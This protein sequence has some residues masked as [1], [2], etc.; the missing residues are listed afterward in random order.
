MSQHWER[1]IARTGCYVETKA[2]TENC[3]Y[4]KHYVAEKYFAKFKIQPILDL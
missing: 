2:K 3:I 1:K 4:T